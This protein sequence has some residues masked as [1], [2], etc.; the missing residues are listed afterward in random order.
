MAE[1]R[2]L[3][4]E[5]RAPEQA[6]LL[7]EI[8]A[9]A[10]Q[11]S[12]AL[13]AS[14]EKEAESK[15]TLAKTKSERIKADAQTRT[16]EQIADMKRHTDSVLSM[17]RKRAHL[18]SQEKRYEAVI[19]LALKKAAAAAETDGYEDIVLGWLVEAAAGLGT[20]NAEIQGGPKEHPLLTDAMMKKAE[21]RVKEF[22]GKTVSLHKS[23]EA[24]PGQG[25]IAKD[26]G[27]RLAWDNRVR[28][29]LS[30]MEQDVRKVV[31]RMLEKERSNP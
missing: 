14:A 25:I 24:C 29:R 30:R 4:S 12:S 23:K 19:S 16:Q 5:T 17:E 10:E 2:T 3:P 26:P 28:I 13:V 6:D 22:T 31:S 15:I 11:E 18:A 8:I 9:E 21:A 27:G 1:N 20:G 7:A